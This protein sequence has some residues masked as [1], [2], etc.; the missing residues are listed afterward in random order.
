MGAGAAPSAGGAGVRRPP[1][2]DFLHLPIERDI[3]DPHGSAGYSRRRPR[4]RPPNSRLNQPSGWFDLGYRFVFVHAHFCR[5]EDPETPNRLGMVN[6][7]GGMLGDVG[8]LV[9]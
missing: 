5:G 8:C 9:E 3:H 7:A 6:S 4:G 2:G 1:A